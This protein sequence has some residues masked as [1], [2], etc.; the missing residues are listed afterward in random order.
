MALMKLE[1]TFDV[2]LSEDMVKNSELE[3]E[4]I[5]E[6]LNKIFALFESKLSIKNSFILGCNRDKTYLIK[7]DLSD[8][9]QDFQ[10][11][12][13]KNNAM[14]KIKTAFIALLTHEI[15]YLLGVITHDEAS[16]KEKQSLEKKLN[17][18]VQHSFFTLQEKWSFFQAKF[19][20]DIRNLPVMSIY[21]I[22]INVEMKWKSRHIRSLRS[23][24]IQGMS[25]AS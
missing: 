23:S 9:Q 11:E 15:P 22:N 8:D 12:V 4:K 6:Y 10:S 2:Q 16:L 3:S 19:W 17:L 13:E 25:K 24:S 14:E 21:D 18:A 1:L 7:L 20:Q 5:F